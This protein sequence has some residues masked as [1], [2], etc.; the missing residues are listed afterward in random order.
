[1]TANAIR[2]VGISYNLLRFISTDFDFDFDFITRRK[3]RH[4]T[5]ATVN[6][7]L[8]AWGGC[9]INIGRVRGL[10]VCGG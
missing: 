2:T 4:T 8:A 9:P 10:G 1:M 3:G 5:I 7:R 6:Q